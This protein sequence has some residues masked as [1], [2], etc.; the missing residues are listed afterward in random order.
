MANE[1]VA[2][3][4]EFITSLN[5]L[6]YR[7]KYTDPNIKKVILP[8]PK[9][10]RSSSLP[11]RPMSKSRIKLEIKSLKQKRS[12]SVD[13][14]SKNENK[15]RL[16][17]SLTSILKTS[18]SPRNINRSVKFDSKQVKEELETKPK[19]RSKTIWIMSAKYSGNKIKPFKKLEEINEVDQNEFERFKTEYK[20][21]EK[22][23]EINRSEEP[24]EKFNNDLM[25]VFDC[26][27]WLARDEGDK[28]IE[29]ILKV[30]QIIKHEQEYD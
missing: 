4:E 24:K 26:N 30:N 27:Q 12:K 11:R 7:L 3:S 20:K 2:Q 14:G 9:I 15:I 16:S 25:F 21:L 5:D 6:R 17:N 8:K 22:L 1:N 10:K 19:I 29:R 28:R 23:N 18:H 13:Y